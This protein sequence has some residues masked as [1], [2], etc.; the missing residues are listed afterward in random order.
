M[1]F[2]F[3]AGLKGSKLN[4]RLEAMWDAL[5]AEEKQSWE[6]KQPKE[7]RSK[8]KRTRSA[9]QLFM[10]DHYAELQEANPGRCGSDVGRRG[11]ADGDVRRHICGVEER[12]RVDEGE[13]PAAGGGGERAR[14]RGER[15]GGGERGEEE[16]EKAERKRRGDQ[17][18][19]TQNVPRTHRQHAVLSGT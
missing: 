8:P 7:K 19:A 13:I 10:A 12:G 17:R 1:E 4:K 9:Y 2:R 5:P 15:R 14:E 18:E 6:A 11:D 3:F 16:R